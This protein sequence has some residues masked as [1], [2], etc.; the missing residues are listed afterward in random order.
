MRTNTIKHKLRDGGTVIGCFVPF[1]SPSA[2]EICG[3]AGFEFILIDAEHGPATTDSAHH[4]VLAAEVA[5]SVPL[6]RVPVNIPQVI[7]R[8]L[9]IGA[10]GVIAPQVNSADEAR[11]VVQAVKY[12]PE[13]LRGIAGVRAAS[14]A[15]NQPL[16]DYAEAANRETFIA[17]QIENIRGVER[18]PE[19][20]EVPGIDVLFVGPNDLAHSMGYTGQINHP[21]VQGTIDR[22]IEMAR[23]SGITLG[24]VAPNAAIANQMI[25]RG[26]RMIGAN[27][28]TLLATGSREMLAAINR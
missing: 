12:H 24:T 6:V 5:G 3:H 4:M 16:T 14:W 19:I 18:V 15:I 17:V 7:L 25:E 22:I 2:A 21:E 28:A 1:S 26:F 8:Y 10:A 13:G 23:P 11:A 20:I 9:D 27:A